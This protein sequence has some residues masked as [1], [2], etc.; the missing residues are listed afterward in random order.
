MK[1]SRANWE[2]LLL[3][4]S[5]M[6]PTGEARLVCAVIAD[7]IV[8]EDKSHL[9]FVSGGFDR[10]CKAVGLDPVF[11]KEQMLRAKTAVVEAA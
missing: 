3:R 7:G 11:V 1:V 8:D 6:Q 4:W 10:Y 2:R 9:F 5:G